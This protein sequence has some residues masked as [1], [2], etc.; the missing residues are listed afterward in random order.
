MKVFLLSIRLLRPPHH[1]CP[2]SFQ[3]KSE[4]V[5]AFSRKSKGTGK[6][7]FAFCLLTILLI[8][9]TGFSQQVLSPDLR[10]IHVKFKEEFRPKI[11]PSARSASSGIAKMDKISKKHNA[12]V[13]QRIF[14]DAGIHEAAHRAYGLHLWYEIKFSKDASLAKAIAD[15]KN[16]D[17]F[18][19]VEECKEYKTGW[20]ENNDGAPEL[21]LGTNDPNLQ[22]NGI[23]KIQ[24]RRV[25]SQ[26]LTSIC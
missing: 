2:N 25:E 24:V 17:Y 7:I 6:F 19:A 5:A 22:N 4:L 3:M 11:S 12:I 18:Y 8:D 23:L 20:E 15:Y 1:C 13:I 10:T 14:P 26:V 16:L 9:N 21:P